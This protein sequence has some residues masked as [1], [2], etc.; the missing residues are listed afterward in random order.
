MSETK[1]EQEARA[2]AHRWHYPPT[3]T[4]GSQGTV[5]RWQDGPG[6]EGDG[7]FAYRATIERAYAAPQPAPADPV[8]AVAARRVELIRAGYERALTPDEAAELSR[9]DSAMR[10]LSPRVTP[11]MI[12]ALARQQEGEVM[13]P[14]L[15]EVLIAV[16]CAALTL[17]IAYP[18]IARA[19][20]G[21][22]G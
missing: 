7:P 20:G 5:G 12:A 3:D 8:D 10:I 6:P 1:R 2:V 14:S 9:L 13:R 18:Y 19:L 22:N 21:G 15:L 16:I 11:E 17:W 4:P